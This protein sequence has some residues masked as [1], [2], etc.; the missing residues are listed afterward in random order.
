MGEPSR[1]TLYFDGACGL[2]VRSTRVLR[3]LDWLGRLEFRDQNTIPDGAL[4][5]A[6]DAAMQ[7][8]P[9]RTRDGRT[10]V[11]YPAT[12]RALLQTPLGCLSALV[13]YLPGVSHIGR[14]VYGRV[15]ANRG[16]NATCTVPAAGGGGA[17]DPR[18]T[19]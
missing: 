10:L 3:A 18:R 19:G 11:G 2:C 1:D 5:V 6:R 13:M 9:M 15:A 16:R 17:A 12:R 8:I 14:S 7:G 4:P